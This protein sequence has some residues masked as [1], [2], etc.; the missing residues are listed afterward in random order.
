M[1]GGKDAKVKVWMI[2]DLISKNFGDTMHKAY[3][4]FSEHTNEITQVKLLGSFRAMS[5]S[6]DKQFKVY[7]LA[8]KLCI[9]TIQT[10]SAISKAVVDHTES[11]VYVACDN[12][13]I[14]CYSL[15]QT[16]SGGK[17][18]HKKTLIHKK[19]VTAVCIS[20]DDQFV[21]SGDQNGVIYIWST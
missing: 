15:E 7:D 10:Q 6:L 3:A 8:S 2:P 12:Q 19:K 20:V 18:K 9:K 13:N 5:A 16:E 4:E 14:Y 17:S 11:Y 21:I 1:T